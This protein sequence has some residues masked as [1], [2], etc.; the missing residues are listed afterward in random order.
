M[1]KARE[2]YENG[3]LRPAVIKALEAKG[4]LAEIVHGGMYQSGFPD[5]YVI[6]PHGRHFWIELKASKKS[7]LRTS[8]L[9]KF[10]RWSKRRVEVFIISDVKDLW[11]TLAELPNWTNW[12]P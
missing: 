2:N 6:S 5:L 10:A 3:I 7:R 8:Q 12:I 11:K 4:Y 1:V 9:E